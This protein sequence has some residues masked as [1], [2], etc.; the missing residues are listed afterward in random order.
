[1]SRGEHATHS[2]SYDRNGQP[3]LSGGKTKNDAGSR[4]A[5]QEKQDSGRRNKPA[6]V[7]R[8]YLAPRLLRLFL[9]PRT[10]R[11]VTPRWAFSP[12][13]PFFVAPAI[14]AKKNTHTHRSSTHNVECPSIPSVHSQPHLLCRPPT[15]LP[16][17][18]TRGDRKTTNQGKKKNK[19]SH[20]YCNS[21]RLTHFSS[22][23]TMRASPPPRLWPVST[24]SLSLIARTYSS[25]GR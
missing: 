7:K 14:Q 9:S 23:P 25:S 21:G 6:A 24:T 12:L 8:P 3:S 15:H 2:N 5:L 11:T 20:K 1:M 18:K 13:S 22:A 19:P 10:E 17:T 16:R 4:K